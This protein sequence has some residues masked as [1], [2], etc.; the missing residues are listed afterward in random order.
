MQGKF[1]MHLAGHWVF[2]M[3]LF[4]RAENLV[5]N[6]AT[7]KIIK[8]LYHASLL[9]PATRSEIAPPTKT[10]RMSK[11]ILCERICIGA[12]KN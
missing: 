5:R 10:L 1:Q 7:G 4:S 6:A 11:L 8:L 3:Y 9:H 12:A 2:L